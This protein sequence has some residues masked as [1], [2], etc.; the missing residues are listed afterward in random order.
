MARPH[1]RNEL[2]MLDKSEVDA[3]LVEIEA[4][5]DQK[6]ETEFQLGLGLVS[7]LDALDNP[8]EYTEE[9][10]KKVFDHAD[11][12]AAYFRVKYNDDILALQDE[13]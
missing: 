9:M 1:K 2:F 11:E 12:M 4:D 10:L 3:Q 5:L 13:D 7:V 8:E 6:S